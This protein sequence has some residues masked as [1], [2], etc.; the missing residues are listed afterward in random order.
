MVEEYWTLV[1]VRRKRSWRARRI[2]HCEGE[3]DRVRFDAQAVLQ[4]EESRGDVVGFFHT[5]PA[6]PPKPSARDVRT[7]RAWCSAFGKPLWCV[8]A[9]P[10]G[11]AG[12][13][14]EDDS[15]RGTPFALV[16]F[17]KN[18]VLRGVERDGR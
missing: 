1:G 2:Q 12:F 5:H 15:S 8:I 3:P 7:M 14:F 18:G 17:L 4:R 6:G 9:S 11:M 16:K 13:C 10:E